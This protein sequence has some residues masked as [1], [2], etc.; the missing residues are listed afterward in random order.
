LIAMNLSKLQHR[1]FPMVFSFRALALVI[2][3]LQVKDFFGLQAEVSGHYWER[4]AAL[5]RAFGTLQW[6]DAAVGALTLGVLIVWPRITR[7]LPAP[8]VAVVLGALAAWA[9]T[10]FAGYPVATIATRFS[11]VVD[12]VTH[13]GIPQVP[14]LPLLP[15]DLPGAD[16]APIGLSWDL[17]TALLG[18]AMAIAAL[19]AI[20]SLLSAV[21]ADGMAGT[22]HDP[23]AALVG[24][25]LGNIAA[26]FFGGFAATGA[27]ARTAT[28]IRSGGR[29]PVAA[30]SHALFVLASV[31]VLAPAL[32]YLPMAGMAALLLIVAWNMSDAKH[33]FHMLRV[34]PRSDVAVMLACFSLTVIFDMVVAVSVGIVLAALLFMRRMAEISGA[35]MAGNGDGTARVE[36]PPGVV[37]YEIAGPLFFG[38]ADKAIGAIATTGTTQ[39]L[40]LDMHAVPA[41]DATGLVAL[42]SALVQLT[43]QRRIAILSGVQSQPLEL[44]ERAGATRREGIELARNAKEALTMA[45]G[46][47]NG[48]KPT[49]PP[50]TPA[51]ASSTDAAS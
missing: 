10:E 15:W 14:P 41:M 27:I 30:V 13:A 16:G 5:G 4:V 29:S 38:A 46:L 3:L 45:E 19:G 51:P 37:L 26:P 12:G 20:E 50:E 40:M 47:V 31:M 21:V 49:R 33:F 6:A 18:P 28:N 1:S 32:G 9:L 22:R 44:L 11:Y 42:E 25:G 24:Q 7:K 48:A 35:R 17:L 43:A 8:L 34:A 23:D 36:L 39:V 2:A